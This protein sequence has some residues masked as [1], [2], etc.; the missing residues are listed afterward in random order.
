MFSVLTEPNYPK[1]AIGLESEAVTALALQREGRGRFGVKQAATIELPS[2]LLTP[3][4]VERNIAS[5]EQL[6]VLLEEAVV[7]AGLMRQTNWS[8]SLPSNTARSAIL[9]LDSDAAAKG[10]AEEILDWKAEQSFG[11]PSGELRITRNKISNDREGKSRYFATAVKLSVIDEYETVFESLGWTA[12]LIL[13]R[14]VSETRWLTRTDPPSDS[15]LLSSQN[16]GFTALLLRGDEPAVVRTVTCRESERDD[17]IFR[18][19]MFYNDRFADPSA[20]GLLETL[21]VIGKDLLPAKIKEISNEALGR[22][23]QVLRADDVGLSV[24]V[25]N[26]SFDDLAAPAGLASLGWR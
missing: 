3:S 17:E 13:P 11:A 25:G 19:L 18:L 23:L 20:G 1:A 14:A 10:E 26:L 12:G 24:P 22:T 15:L 4:F 16:D 21:L 8:V 7:S 2:N 6:R 5:A 9:T